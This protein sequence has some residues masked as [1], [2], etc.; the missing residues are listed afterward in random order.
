[1]SN[2]VVININAFGLRMKYQVFGEV[3]GV[4]VVA[5]YLYNSKYDTVV[6]KLLFLPND[7]SVT[8][9]L[10]NILCLSYGWR[11]TSLFLAIS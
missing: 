5:F 1:M 2:K 3:Y 4:G 10:N 7:L 8:T 9:S 6:N 11:Y